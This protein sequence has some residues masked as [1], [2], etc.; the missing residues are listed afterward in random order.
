[1]VTSNKSAV[2]RLSTRELLARR[3]R[4]AASVGDL[5]HVL[6]GS[7]VEQTR[8]CGKPG[9]RCAAGGTE[10]AHGPYPYFTQRRGRRGMKY[11]PS[12]LLASVRAGL[13]RGEEVEAVLAEISAIN[14]E[15]LA[16]RAIR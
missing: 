15:L 5:E 3:S 14:V 13:Q 16:R 12:A 9:C 4:L 7:V 11:V 6:L 8:R 10:H 1:V 2:L